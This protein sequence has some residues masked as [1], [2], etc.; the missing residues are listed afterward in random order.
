[1]VFSTSISET[2]ENVCFY[3]MIGF[4][5][6]LHLF[7]C[8]TSLAWSEINSKHCRVNQKKIKSSRKEYVMWMCFKFWPMK[9]IFQKL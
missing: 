3:F 4:P 1:M 5:W 7:T 9:S 2:S 6:S 8:N